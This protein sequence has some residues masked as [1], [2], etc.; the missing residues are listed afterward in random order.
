MT[1]GLRRFARS[2]ATRREVAALRS[3]IDHLLAEP[4]F[5][6]PEGYGPAIPWPA[7]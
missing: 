7:F 5:P 4:R 3:R 2:A 1:S 6:G